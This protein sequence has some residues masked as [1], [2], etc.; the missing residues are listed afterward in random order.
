MQNENS[1][2][3]MNYWQ[4]TK[5]KFFKRPTATVRLDESSRYITNKARMN[6]EKKNSATGNSS[7]FAICMP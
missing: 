1:G 6:Y 5:V 3:D 7:A 4:H 2:V